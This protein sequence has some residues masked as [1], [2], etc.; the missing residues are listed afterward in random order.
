LDIG[1][2]AAGFGRQ[3]EVVGIDGADAIH[4]PEV[5]EHLIARLG[6]D[7]TAAQAGIAA[8]RHHG[9]LGF[10]QGADDLGGLLGCAGQDAQPAAPLIRA[11]LLAQIG[12]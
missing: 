8:L 4:A 6:R 5:D 7:G 12:N 1:Q 10:V 11:A 3:R 9:H 2:D